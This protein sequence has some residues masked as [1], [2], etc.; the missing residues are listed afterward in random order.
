VTRVEQG[1]PI[2]PG[3]Y[4]TGEL[5]GIEQSLVVE[6]DGQAVV[7]AGCSH[8]GVRTILRAAS[9]FG[10][11]SVLLGGLHGFNDFR[12][13]EDLDRICPAHCTRY[14]GEIGRRY[15]EKTLAAGAGRVMEI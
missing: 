13:I 8:P 11:V 3:L 4:S 1:A 15:P 5:G 12:L 10:R 14:L 9:K 2:G 7:V 6:H